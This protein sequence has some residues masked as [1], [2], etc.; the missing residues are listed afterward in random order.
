MRAAR[1]DVLVPTGGEAVLLH[2]VSVVHRQGH[3]PGALSAAGVPSADLAE[4]SPIEIRPVE[5][6]PLDTA[7]ADRLSE[8]WPTAEGR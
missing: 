5:V 2:L 7:T 4:P 6:A 3:A 8:S 1:P